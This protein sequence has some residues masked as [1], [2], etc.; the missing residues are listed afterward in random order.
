MRRLH[1][2]D[3]QAAVE[4]ILM[5]PFVMVLFLFIVEFG[6][7]LHA[8]ISIVQSSAEA[9]RYA[10]IGKAPAAGACT[11]NDGTIQG[12]AVAASQLT[13]TCAD[14]TVRYQPA[15]PVA[16]G[17]IVAVH[18]DHTY[19]PITPL[20]DMLAF[21]SFGTFPGTISIGSCFDA[22]LETGPTVQTNVI[23]GAGC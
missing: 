4:F 17:D 15:K 3:G 11:A 20:G 22:R 2:Q 8:Y 14:V 7:V 10:A 19:T 16:R 23:V 1:R 6:F 9:A 13:V 18:I 5:F 12:R 21:L